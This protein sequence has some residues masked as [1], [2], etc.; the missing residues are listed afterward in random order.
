MGSGSAGSAFELCAR[1]LVD[2]ASSHMLVP[3]AFPNGRSP[4]C[5]GLEMGR[6]NENPF[7]QGG[8]LKISGPVRI[9]VTSV[10][11]EEYRPRALFKREVTALARIARR[12]EVGFGAERR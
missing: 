7:S 12:R 8:F 10:F 2:P 3:L 1:Y 11:F 6:T 4:V 9:E 5:D